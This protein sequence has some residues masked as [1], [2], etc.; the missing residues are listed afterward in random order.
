M[1]APKIPQGWRKLKIGELRRDGDK[2]LFGNKWI[3]V[4]TFVGYPVRGW[5]TAVIRPISKDK[6][7]RAKLPQKAIA[8]AS[9]GI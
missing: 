6:S 9:D 7:K 8:K 1:V 4:M 5:M 3:P 2:F